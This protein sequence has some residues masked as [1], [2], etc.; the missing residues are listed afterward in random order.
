MEKLARTKSYEETEE[1]LIS[2]VVR[3]GSDVS[4]FITRCTARMGTRD[5]DERVSSSRGSLPGWRTPTSPQPMLTREERL[6]LLATATKAGPAS[7]MGG[8]G[9]LALAYIAVIFTT[10]EGKGRTVLQSL[11]GRYNQ[12]NRD[13]RVSG[14]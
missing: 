8:V 6:F 12:T 9:G 2:K 13:A 4:R 10:R 3:E 11:R 1:P 7:L 14:W 5:Q